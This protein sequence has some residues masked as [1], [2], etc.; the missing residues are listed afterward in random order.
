VGGREGRARRKDRGA[1]DAVSADR[2][3]LSAQAR[4]DLD[5][6]IEYL[7]LRN[8]GAAVEVS[9]SIDAALTVLAA[10]TPRMD[11]PAVRLQSGA[12]CRRHHAH[13][14]VIFYERAPGLLFVQAIHHHA[15]EPIAR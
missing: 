15:R 8:P 7:L 4:A 3:E 13:P 2:I 6:L 5:D 11:G 9:A 1:P 14:V 12:A 10:S